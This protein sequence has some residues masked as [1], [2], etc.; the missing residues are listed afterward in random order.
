MMEGYGKAIYTNG[1]IYYGNWRIDSRDGTGTM[2]Y[3][4]GRL[5]KGKFNLKS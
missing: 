5:Y 2:K 3:I 4:D 1:D